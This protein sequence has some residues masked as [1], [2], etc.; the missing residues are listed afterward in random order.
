MKQV[1]RSFFIL[2]LPLLVMPRLVFAATAQTVSGQTS[3]SLAASSADTSQEIRSL[4]E[5]MKKKRD[6][7]EVTQK[8]IQI[9]ENAISVKQGERLTL[10]KQL[11]VIEE[12][13]TKTNLDVEATK[14]GLDI[15]GLELK[16][17]TIELQK[18][19][20]QT[21][22]ERD[23]LRLVMVLMQHA[24]DRNP[25]EY[26]IG[27]KNFSQ[28]FDVVAAG[29]QL[30]RAL[31]TSLNRIKDLSAQTHAKKDEL[32]AQEQ[33]QKKLQN[34][35]IGQRQQLEEDRRAKEYLVASTQDSEKKFQ[36][37]LEAA[38]NEQEQANSDIE[39]I[40]K[41]I[42]E[43]LAAH[44][45]SLK[46]IGIGEGVAFAWPVPFQGIAT[47]FHDPGYVFRRIF[48]HPG[49]DLRTLKNGVPTAGMFVRAAASGYV[50]QARDAGMG[51]S[52]I[53]LIHSNKLSTVYGHVAKILVKPEQYVNQ[54]DV[55]GLSGGL[56]G[57]PGAG[58]LTTGPHLHFE[59][60]SNGI[61]VNP[62]QYL[63]AG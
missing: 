42:R 16:T 29:E 14:Q 35:L 13:A 50:G 30:S 44:P 57:T 3:T 27:A 15:L 17:T 40:E 37:F 22:Q 43:K 25:L 61:P 11:S 18:L 5:E 23:R 21:D 32:T 7:L 38:R 28:L 59:V 60:R 53:M 19:G 8:Q 63:S 51:Y 54:G 46:R 31:L 4:Q 24:G 2:V 10:Q 41:D 12:S 47:Q 20:K 55:I 36:Q 1:H 9:Y 58:R 56:P 45:E 39:R 49:V 33:R 26:F 52:Y 6:A 34:T 48:E 62:L